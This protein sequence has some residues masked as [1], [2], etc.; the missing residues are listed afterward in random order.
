MNSKPEF[1]LCRVCSELINSEIELVKA[2]EELKEILMIDD[3]GQY[4]TILFIDNNV[5]RL[6]INKQ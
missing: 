5:G 4:S 3:D 2:Q 6:K 1:S